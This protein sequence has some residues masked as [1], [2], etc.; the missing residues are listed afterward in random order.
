MGSLSTAAWIGHNLGIAAGVGGTLFGQ[1]ALEPS[2]SKIADPRERGKVVNDAWRRFGMV[3]LGALGLMTA[4]WFAGRLKLTG[5][6]V[7][8]SSRGLVL[9]KDVLVA[10]SLVSAIGAA[11]AGNKMASHRDDGAVPLNSEGKVSAAVPS[12]TRQLG[13]LTDGLG[14]VNLVAGVGVIAVTTM[15]SMS[16]GRSVR[17]SAVSRL[18]P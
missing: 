9:A 1:V 12:E 5:L 4:T 15:L 11:V 6:D 13:R 2:M 7:S 16:A 3:Q 18:L 17:W 10:G 14:W 8:G